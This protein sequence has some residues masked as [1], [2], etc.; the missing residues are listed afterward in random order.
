MRKFYKKITA[1]PKLV[2][3]LFVIF[4]VFGAVCKPLVSVN[5]DMNDYLPEDSKSTVSLDVMNEEFDGGIPNAR[6]MIKDVTVPEALEYKEKIEAVEGV[7]GVMWLD[8][9]VDMMTPLETQDKDVVENYYKD[10]TALYSVTI[11]EEHILDGVAAI[12]GIIGEDNAMSGSAVST[13]V[14]TKSTVS[15]IA[16]ITVIAVIFVL[17]ILI[18]TTT[19]W[20]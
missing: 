10:N 4:A 13:E 9:S 15:E 11:E 18:L 20:A 14:A 2:I 8:D 17:L 19:S 7:S 16:K 5:Y 1:K 6:V 12:R 3:V